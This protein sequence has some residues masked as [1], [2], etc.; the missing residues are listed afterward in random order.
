MVI[1][2]FVYGLVVIYGY[3]ENQKQEIASLDYFLCFVFVLGEVC[4]RVLFMGIRGGV[5]QDGQVSR[6]QVL[7]IIF[8]YFVLGVYTIEVFFYFKLSFWF[9]KG[10]FWSFLGFSLG[11]FEVRISRFVRIIQYQIL[12]FLC[13]FR[14]GRSVFYLLVE[15]FYVEQLGYKGI[16]YFFQKF[17][18]L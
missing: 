17:F 15:Y 11:V 16:I 1:L 9:Q 2:E 3:F 7:R 14:Q 13:V 18:Y 12:F 6:R 5:S 10:C 4:S 8:L